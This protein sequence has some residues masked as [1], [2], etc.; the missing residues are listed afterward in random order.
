MENKTA[1][2]LYLLPEATPGKEKYFDRKLCFRALSYS[3]QDDKVFLQISEDRYD[4][5]KLAIH[6][7]Y[8]LEIET[9]N[10][11]SFFYYYLKGFE[12]ENME[13]V[14]NLTLYVNQLK[15]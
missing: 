12:V 9:E 5:K 15:V 7:T 1:Y 8:I 13:S 6:Q 14:F 2:F 3:T 4:E 11:S 10:D